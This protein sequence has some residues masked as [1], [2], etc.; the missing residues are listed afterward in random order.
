MV[1]LT[2]FIMS[3]NSIF[4]AGLIFDCQF[5][6]ILQIIKKTNIKLTHI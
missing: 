2:I 4:N 5:T 1:Q 6:I 3:V